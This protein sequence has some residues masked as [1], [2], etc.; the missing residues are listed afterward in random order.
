MTDE[1]I[2]RKFKG[3][4]KEWLNDSEMDAYIE[5]FLNL[6]RIPQLGN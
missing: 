6:E 2:I 1:D 3:L 5:S 4:A